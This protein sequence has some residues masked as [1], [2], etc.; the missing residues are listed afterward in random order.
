MENSLKVRVLSFAY[1][2]GSIL[3]AGLATVI[4]SQE[5]SA[6]VKEYAGTATMGTIALLLV[7]EVVKFM[8]NKQV[9]AN[10]E[11]RL[12]GKSST[13]TNIPHQVTLI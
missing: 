13:I 1:N 3:V 5:F 6:L 11:L 2:F 10:A 9:I 12:I 8:R 4:S 7:Q